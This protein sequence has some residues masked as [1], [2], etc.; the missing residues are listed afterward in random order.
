MI[1][2]DRI[3]TVKRLLFEH[4]KS[5]SLRHIKDPYMLIKLAQEIVRKLDRGN[6]PWTKW[7]GPREQL[8]KSATACWIP[9]G[10]LRDCST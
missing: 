6:S 10:D 5:P 9:T 7:T 8:L 4:M 1:E 3:D 2:D